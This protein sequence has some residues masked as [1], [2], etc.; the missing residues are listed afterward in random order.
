MRTDRPLTVSGG[1]VVWP[2]GGGVSGREGEGD[3]QT[4]TCEQNDT[5]LWKHNLK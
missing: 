3:R 1:G 2:G 5:R 4:P